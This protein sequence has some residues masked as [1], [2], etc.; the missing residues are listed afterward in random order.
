MQNGYV[1]PL[2][3]SKLK[4]CKWVLQINIKILWFLHFFK[5]NL[6]SWTLVIKGNGLKLH[7]LICEHEKGSLRLTKAHESYLEFDRIKA[8]FVLAKFYITQTLV[9]LSSTE[10]S[11][12][13]CLNDSSYFLCCLEWLWHEMFQNST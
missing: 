8:L 5:W 2:F 4:N 9:L 12:A 7:T 11:W 13:C 3:V 1:S 6:T 10:D